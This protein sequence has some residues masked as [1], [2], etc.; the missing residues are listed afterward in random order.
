VGTL[1][2]L[3]RCDEVEVFFFGCD[4]H[5]RLQIT[6]AEA[7]FRFVIPGPATLRAMVQFLDP[8]DSGPDRL[9]VGVM[10]DE[11]VMLDR[12]RSSE[13]P[14]FWLNLAHEQGLLKLKFAEPEQARKFVVA[15]RLAYEDLA[16][17]AG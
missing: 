14:K 13:T 4:D 15:V 3:G 8:R 1:A 7:T 11:E 9:Q 6:T 10:G 16:S 17:K 5:D 12:D 2:A